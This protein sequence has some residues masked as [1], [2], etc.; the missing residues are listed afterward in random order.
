MASLVINFWR[1]KHVVLRNDLI[2]DDRRRFDLLG[3]F[4]ITYVCSKFYLL[5]E[6]VD[7]MKFQMAID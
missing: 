4:V 2:D 6:I 5:F 1:T 7:Y 3:K